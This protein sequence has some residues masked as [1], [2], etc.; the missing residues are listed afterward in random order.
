MMDTFLSNLFKLVILFLLVLLGIHVYKTYLTDENWDDTQ[1]QIEDIIDARDS[2][3]N[4]EKAPVERLDDFLPRSA[5]DNII[6]HE[7]FT[8]SYSEKDEQAKW[9]AYELNRRQV[10]SFISDR[11]DNFRE[12]DKIKSGSARLSD[13]RG[14]GYD[15]GHLVPAGDMVFS[16]IAMSESFLLSNIS[17]Q[18]KSFNRGIWKE[19]EQQTRDW[20]RANEHLYIVT[21]PVLWKRE[22]TKIGDSRVSVPK[23][24]YKA[25]LDLRE[26]KQKAVAFLIPHDKQTARLEEFAMSIDD[27][28]LETGIDFFP[29][30]PNEQESE[31]EANFNPYAWI[32]DEE[33]Y[34]QRLSKWNYE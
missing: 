34:R 29:S 18:K 31:I 6:R 14:S 28:E 9:V 24:Y 30:L 25:L 26:P 5:K 33:R 10:N 2:L 13:Y 21:G 8:L 7:F 19:L 32:Y 11:T 16:E 15:R 3:D 17:P 22:S 20:V 27:L 12:D 4:E 1:N 23:A